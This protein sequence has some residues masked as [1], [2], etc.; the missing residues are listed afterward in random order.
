MSVVIMK[1]REFRKDYGDLSLFDVL[2]AG[3][4][5][6]GIPKDLHFGFVNFGQDMQ[7]VLFLIK[8]GASCGRAMMLEGSGGKGSGSASGKAWAGNSWWGSQGAAGSTAGVW[9]SQ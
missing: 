6:D 1:L 8:E 9:E 4:D 7:H 5:E 3:I 2:A